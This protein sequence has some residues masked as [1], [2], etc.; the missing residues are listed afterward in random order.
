V[1]IEVW[2][3]GKKQD[4]AIEKMSG[5]AFRSEQMKLQFIESGKHLQ[6]RDLEGNLQMK[7]YGDKVEKPLTHEQNK[8]FD[9]RYQALQQMRQEKQQ[10]LAQSGATKQASQAEIGG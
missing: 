9:T 5:T 10:Q 8:S 7:A 4:A 3:G 6:V 1:P 2:P